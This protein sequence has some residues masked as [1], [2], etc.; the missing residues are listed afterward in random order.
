LLSA[1]FSEQLGA[2]FVVDNRPGAAGTI[3]SA[4]VAK[5]T[6]DGYTLLVTAPEMSIDPSLRLNLPYNVL[7]DFAPISQLTSGPYMLAGHP[8]LPIK[9]VKDLIALAKAHP[10]KLNYGSSGTG[11]INH[12]K[13]ELLRV[14]AGI[15]LEHVAFKGVGPAITAVMG[16]EIE[17]VFASTT[18]LGQHVKSGRL[19]GLG[20]TGPKR[21]AVLPDVP[22][23]AE[24]G[25]P[26]YSVVGWY[27]LFAPAGTPAD[28]VRRLHA[29]TARA[30]LAKD[31]R[32]KLAGTGNE[33]VASSPAEFAEFLRAE[34]D[35]WA[36]VIKTAGI[37]RIE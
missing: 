8:S 34:I 37:K 27:A 4:H 5:A 28:I 26:G 15:R 33:P 21:F 1:K 10:G 2:T 16:G 19:R 9:T 7:K 17:L 14:M 18:A 22:T 24:S 25:V 35:K 12:L 32:E 31:A 11:S 3:G 29:E 23:I 20:V 36:S 6:A 30:L 13:G